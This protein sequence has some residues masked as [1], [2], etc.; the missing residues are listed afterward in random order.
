M[1]AGT[2]VVVASIALLSVALSIVEFRRRIPLAFTCQR[3][4]YEFR[5][6]SHRDYPPACPRCHARDWAR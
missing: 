4:G 2:I 5:Q 1:V 6:A 3:C